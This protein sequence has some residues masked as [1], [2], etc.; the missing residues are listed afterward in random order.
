MKNEEELIWE[1]Y[2]ILES[3]KDYIN[4]YN[5]TPLAKDVVDLFK[6]ERHRIP[7]PQNDIGFWMKKPPAILWQFLHNEL[8][9]S[10]RQI[11]KRQKLFNINDI[12]NDSNV[13]L[14][15]SDANWIIIGIRNFEGASKWGSKTTDWCVTKDEGHYDSYTEDGIFV[16]IFDLNK[17]PYNIHTEDGDP[18]SKLAVRID[19]NVEILDI[20]NAPDVEVTSDY[21]LYNKLYWDNIVQWVLKNF[22]ELSGFNFDKLYDEAEDAMNEANDNLKYGSIS[23]DGQDKDDWYVNG[24]FSYD[25]S[26]LSYKDD[27][28]NFDKKLK[29]IL[30]EHC[31]Y[32]EFEC[33]DG[34]DFRLYINPEYTYGRSFDGGNNPITDAVR[35][36]E[37]ILEDLDKNYYNTFYRIYGD[38]V[39]AGLIEDDDPIG[40]LLNVYEDVIDN[41][42]VILNGRS[43]HSYH[44]QLKLNG[45]MNVYILNRF[46]DLKEEL[47]RQFELPL[48]ES[49]HEFDG[50]D[51]DTLV[52]NLINIRQFKYG[53]LGAGID[54][55]ILK[56]IERSTYRTSS[57]DEPKK[58]EQLNLKVVYKILEDDD[59]LRLDLKNI[60][61]TYLHTESKTT[62]K[63]VFYS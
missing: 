51:I 21:D 2:V 63:K 8:H 15:H 59:K 17:E 26:G 1:S 24:Y 11:A 50:Q 31:D 14:I 9:D 46:I 42:I 48:G 52:S 61:D 60:M 40:K 25:L 38:F 22:D 37:S 53:Y 49:V 29:Y 43:L 3:L 13:N 54:I 58:E 4:K 41:H 33:E 6:K 62:F 27:I 12:K 19:G 20:H 39:K 57:R 56:I 35:E 23:M 45:D 5:D 16:F 7:S 28:L 30:D 10:K 32:H 47:S 36:V 55:E 18:E 44:D 34:L